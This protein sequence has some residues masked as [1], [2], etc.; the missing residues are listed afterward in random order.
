[1]D[2]C[3][4]NFICA[5]YKQDSGTYHTAGYLDTCDALNSYGDR[6]K[7]LA[8]LKDSHIGAF[9]VIKLLVYY[10][11]Y[12][13]AAFIVVQKAGNMQIII[14]AFTFYLSRIISGLAAVNFRG[15]RNN[16]MLHTFTSVTARKRVNIML[17]MQLI[18]CICMCSIV[19]AAA[20]AVVA[21]LVLLYYRHMAYK[22][23]G[24][25]TG[26]LAGYLLCVSELCMTAAIAVITLI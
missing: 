13:A 7:K 19:T 22:Q 17:V 11:L 25:V 14:M 18:L 12:F 10:V 6:E 21:F 16:G 2:I 9:A 24:G 8:I 5:G 26:D 3:R 15:A 4:G 23:F 1:M 20:V